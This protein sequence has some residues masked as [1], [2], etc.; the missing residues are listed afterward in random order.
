M[1]FA[2]LRH[3]RDRRSTVRGLSRPATF[4]PQGLVTLSAVYS[5]RARAGLL[6]CRRRPWD[7][8]LRSFLLPQGIRYVTARKDPH[9][10][11]TSV[12]PVAKRR[13]GPAVRGFWALTLARVPG[14]QRGFRAL[15]RWLLPWGSPLPGPASESLDRDSA[16]SPL[17]RFAVR[18]WTHP[19]APQSFDRLPAH[20]PR[21]TRQAALCGLD[22]PHR[23]FAPVRS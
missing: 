10:V 3:I 4:R 11:P 9:A 13:A 16:R 8:P 19:P 14:G 6:S 21:Q 2:S 20:P 15:Y 23:V 18:P 7:L 17:T 5:L 1:G 22:S 12:F